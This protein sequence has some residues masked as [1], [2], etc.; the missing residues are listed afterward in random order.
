MPAV[1]REVRMRINI[2]DILEQ[3]QNA[4]INIR[5]VMG[6]PQP[7]SLP[8]LIHVSEALDLEDPEPEIQ[9]QPEPVIEVV[10]EREEKL[11]AA[12]VI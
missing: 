6:E 5:E 11:N 7:E 4:Q 10:L 1:P 12:Q 8:E 9:P 2:K 3:K